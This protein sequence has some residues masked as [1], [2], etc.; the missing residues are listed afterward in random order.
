MKGC[1]SLYSNNKST[2]CLAVFSSRTLKQN[3]A[4]SKIAEDN[5]KHLNFPL[6]TFEIEIISKE[7]NPKPTEVSGKILLTH[8][9]LFLTLKLVIPASYF[10]FF[11]SGKIGMVL[12][13]AGG[14]LTSPFPAQICIE[15]Q[16]GHW[17]F[18]LFCRRALGCALAVDFQWQKLMA[19]SSNLQNLLLVDNSLITVSKY[20]G[21]RALA[22]HWWGSEP[23]R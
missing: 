23:W 14:C 5:I 11:F 2:V 12:S 19:F 3:K 9:C 15:C 8:A 20:A 4:K 6:L 1:W 22:R 18:T 13:A 10:F 7:S 16:V 17:Q 21:A